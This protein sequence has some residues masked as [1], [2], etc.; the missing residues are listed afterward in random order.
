[1][2]ER[3]S[4]IRRARW[5]ELPTVTY[6]R[7]VLTGTIVTMN[8]PDSPV[9]ALG[10][11]ALRG[12]PG[13]STA[14][15]R[16]RAAWA[17]GGAVAGDRARAARTHFIGK[18][19]LMVLDVVLSNQRRYDRRVVPMLDRWAARMRQVDGTPTLAWLRDNPGSYDGLGLRRHEPRT[20]AEVTSGLLRYGATHGAVDEDGACA[21]WAVGTA[22]LELAPKIDPYVGS[23][24]GI[25][26]AL[27]AYCRLLCGADTIK[28]DVRVL[29]QMRTFGVQIPPADA[30]AGFVVAGAMAQEVGVSLA[31]LDQL[32]WYRE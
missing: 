22:G 24:H 17:D 26:P 29:K 8:A 21:G 4:R 30:A 25:G 13:W 7:T 15:E 1:M 2:A 14:I 19:G 11:E 16:L 9:H 6:R 5:Y 3:G 31:E 23:V 32:L 28:P 20:I 18:R 27:F 12:T 10:L